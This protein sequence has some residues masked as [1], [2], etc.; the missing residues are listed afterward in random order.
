MAD[1]ANK[2]W[3]VSE[4][5]PQVAGSPSLGE[6][7]PRHQHPVWRPPWFLP[8]GF[9]VFL[10]HRG[11]CDPTPSNSHLFR[12]SGLSVRKALG[13]RIQAYGVPALTLREEAG[14]SPVS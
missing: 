12:E 11:T 1:T 4:A 13:W 5:G 10:L 2:V 14:A 7:L 6:P 9:S 3:D 8:P